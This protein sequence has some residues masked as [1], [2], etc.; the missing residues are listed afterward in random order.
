MKR[1]EE[2]GKK[3][4]TYQQVLETFPMCVKITNV[5]TVQTLKVCL[6]GYP[7][8]NLVP[9]KAFVCA[10]ENLRIFNLLISH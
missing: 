4:R 7:R 1:G 9:S 5:G 2:F 6:K 10:L 3:I 8:V